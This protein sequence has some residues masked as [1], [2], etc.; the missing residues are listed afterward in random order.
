[1]TAVVSDERKQLI[2]AHEWI[3]L[4]PNY[5]LCGQNELGVWFDDPAGSTHVEKW[6]QVEE[7]LA[8]AKG[9]A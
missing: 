8:A 4:F 6:P 2:K 9:A 1:M 7:A 5:R 3:R